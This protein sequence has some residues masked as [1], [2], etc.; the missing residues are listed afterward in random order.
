MIRSRHSLSIH[1]SGRHSCFVGKRQR[2]AVLAIS[3]ILLVIMTI[4]GITALNTTKLEQRMSGNFQ[5]TARAFEA[6][7]TGLSDQ[8]N[9]TLQDAVDQ[10]CASTGVPDGYNTNRTVCMTVM[11]DY[12]MDRRATDINSATSFRR[13][14][15]DVQSTGEARTPDGD[16]IASTTVH[17]GFVRTI[18]NE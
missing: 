2:G 12:S 1:S 5:A 17:G 13:M 7:E 6:A 18:G 9:T 3:L 11:G 8:V 16:V 10:P 14:L 4:I 15:F